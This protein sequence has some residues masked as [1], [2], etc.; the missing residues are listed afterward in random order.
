MDLLEF[1]FPLD[2]DRSFKLISVEDNHNQLRIMKN[3]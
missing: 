1:R 3:M 2:F